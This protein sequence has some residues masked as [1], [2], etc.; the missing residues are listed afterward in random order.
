[1]KFLLIALLGLT[2]IPAQA[3][4][5]F[6]I[7]VDRSYRRHK[8]QD[9]ERRIWELERA[10]AQ[11]QDK[12]FHLQSGN[13]KNKMWVCTITAVGEN[14]KGVGQSKAQAEMRAFKDCK[15]KRKNTYFCKNAKCEY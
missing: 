10:V 13:S 8:N 2:Q 11:L 9:L 12:V 7:Q 6:R 14:Y 4:D 15:D 1:M 3:D 5:V